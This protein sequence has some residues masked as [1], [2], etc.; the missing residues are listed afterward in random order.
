MSS[1][2]GKDVK[3]KPEA[4]K[5][6]IESESTTLVAFEDGDSFVALRFALLVECLTLMPYLL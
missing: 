1:D 2:K 6:S 5:M 4:K 3:K